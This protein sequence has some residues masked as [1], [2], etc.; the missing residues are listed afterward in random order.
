MIEEKIQDTLDGPIDHRA[1]YY[2]MFY[3]E[4]NHI[5]YFWCDGKS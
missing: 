5:E 2:T 3:F 1:I 4:L